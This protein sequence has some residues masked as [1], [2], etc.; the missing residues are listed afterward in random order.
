[1]L[2]AAGDNV[3]VVDGTVETP[4]DAVAILRF[5]EGFVERG[6]GRV[7]DGM[8]VNGVMQVQ[9]QVCV[10]TVNRT[11]LRQFGANF[12]R[13]A[14]G[15]FEGTQP[16]NLIGVPN[17]AARGTTAGNASTVF[18]N[19]NGLNTNAVL[20]P[21]S[22]IFFGVTTLNS[23]FFGFLEALRQNG[24][25]KILATPTLMTLNG[26]PADF[27]VGGE[28]PVPIV[29]N[30][31]G[32]LQPSVDYVPSRYTPDVCARRTG[33]RPNPFERGPR[34]ES[35]DGEHQPGRRLAGATAIRDITGQRH[36]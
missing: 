19:F 17:I 16:G 31:G 21:N 20:S 27:L 13:G 29:T 3:L 36:G 18:P 26:R 35:F 8:R 24:S 11:A 14:T 33:R 28:Q 2:T 22:T 10:A 5:L 6:V 34:G 1:M 12:L 9:L 15:N 32:S 7:I 4:T 23:S 30:T 25:A